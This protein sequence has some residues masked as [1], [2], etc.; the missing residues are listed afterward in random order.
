MSDGGREN[1]AAGGEPE[2]KEPAIRVTD[3]RRFGPDGEP[4]EDPPDAARAP[5]AARDEGAAARF[6]ELQRA[7]AA[8]VDENRAY[9]Q[10]LEREKDR[11]VAAERA[12]V[13]QAL[14]EAHDELERAWN[15]SRSSGSGEPPALRD[16]REGVRL[17]LQGLAKRVTDLGAVRLELRGTPFDPTTAEAVDLV[18]VADAAQDGLVVD[19]VRPG[20][21]LGDRVLRP[22]RVRVGRLPQA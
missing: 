20:W 3:R 5:A 6:E 10:R 13:I 2:G 22:A 19:E 16:L 14:L 7:Y 15:A 21:R 18:T 11:V 8:L 1:Q 4:R 12:N 17:T 9:R